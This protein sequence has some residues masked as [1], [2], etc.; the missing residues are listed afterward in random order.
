MISLNL[1][2]NYYVLTL[3]ISALFF[4]VAYAAPLI[5]NSSREKVE[6]FSLVDISGTKHDLENYRG[7]VVIISLWT[8]WCKPCIRELKMLNKLRNSEVDNV[9][10][11]A[12]S[13]D[14][15]NTASR[16]YPVSRRNRF[17]FPVLLDTDST[18]S[19]ILNPRGSVPYTLY[20]DR[21][22]KVAYTKRGFVSGDEKEIRNIV[23][24][25]LMES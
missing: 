18:I 19:A 23:N 21:S 1:I 16:V 4:N 14:G 12:L 25:L 11:L 15:P 13:V 9:E 8:T 24:L 2:K 6:N 17:K 10:V 20:I 3:L 22:G 7:K 5:E